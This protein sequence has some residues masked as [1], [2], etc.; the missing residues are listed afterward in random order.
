MAGQDCF[1]VSFHEVEIMT[2]M[3]GA[4]T[5]LL[6][7]PVIPWLST[8][9]QCP[10]RPCRDFIRLALLY[11]V[12]SNIKL[13][14]WEE[15]TPTPLLFPPPHFNPRHHS[16]YLQKIGFSPVRRPGLWHFR[17]C[18]TLITVWPYPGQILINPPSRSAFV[19]LLTPHPCIPLINYWSQAIPEQ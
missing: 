13:A 5:S 6:F 18:S 11:P 4:D 3:R 17:Q 19:E 10:L 2:M 14:G 9:H 15:G 12:C 8:V 1:C 16:E 7:T